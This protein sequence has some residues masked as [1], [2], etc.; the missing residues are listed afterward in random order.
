V[1]AGTAPK[2]SVYLE[3]LKR[4]IAEKFERARVPDAKPK[5]G[6]TLDQKAEILFNVA[7][8]KMR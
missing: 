2:K 6:L 5:T 4:E 3:N 1:S 7:L 8:R